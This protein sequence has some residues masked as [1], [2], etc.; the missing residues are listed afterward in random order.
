[1]K[2]LIFYT[3]LCVSFIGCVTSKDIFSF[4]YDLN[5]GGEIGTGDFI[6]F[7]DGRIEKGEIQKFK[8]G[9]GV[10][11]KLG[12]VTLNN[13]KYDVKDISV[14]QI[15]SNYYRRVPGIKNFMQRKKG[16]KIN[17]YYQHIRSS[18]TDSKGS[19]Y[20]TE[21]DVYYIQK[22]LTNEVQKFSVKL[23]SEMVSDNV[24]A[25]GVLANYGKANNKDK[26]LILDKTIDTYNSE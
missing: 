25:T 13:I 24:K 11:N 19:S 17:L 22:G 23:L 6:Q 7:K 1:M 3:L 18:G 12:S 8:L 5:K 10:L 4:N 15:D 16:G 2:A 21:Y 9:L 20:V 26:R 14:F